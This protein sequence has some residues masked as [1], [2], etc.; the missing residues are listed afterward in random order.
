MEPQ[1]K[2]IDRLLEVLDEVRLLLTSCVP[3]A[4]AP[5]KKRP[6]WDDVW[7]KTSYGVRPST[8]LTP[9]VQSGSRLSEQFTRALRALRL[10]SY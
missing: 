2:D 9:A 7:K 3:S 10:S 6:S 8:T 5:Q 1:G 4:P